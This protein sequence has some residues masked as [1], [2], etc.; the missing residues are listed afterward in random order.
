[1]QELK[2]HAT[3]QA[4]EITRLTIQKTTW[5]AEN[6]EYLTETKRIQYESLIE[7]SEIKD[8]SDAI[9]CI[10]IAKWR[11]KDFL[12]RKKNEKIIKDVHKQ[13]RNLLSKIK[14]THGYLFDPSAEIEII[15]HYN[16]PR[17]LREKFRAQQIEN[18][19]NM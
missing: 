13:L 18:I 1:M 9:V 17:R 15:D 14:L 4:E 10:K 11:A 7:E 3:L 6:T 16:R 2:M 12:E 5:E 8:F 19:I